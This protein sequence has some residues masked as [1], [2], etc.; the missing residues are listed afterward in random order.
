MLAT[1]VPDR[2]SSGLRVT[3]S[4]ATESHKIFQGCRVVS[5]EQATQI[6]FEAWQLSMTLSR[7]P[8]EESS[9]LEQPQTVD[10][11]SRISCTRSRGMCPTRNL[12]GLP[13]RAS[14]SKRTEKGNSLESVSALQ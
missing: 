3:T 7:F 9:N 10:I 6:C 1:L 13:G 4:S 11:R 8:P 5:K 14:Y 2:L 12:R